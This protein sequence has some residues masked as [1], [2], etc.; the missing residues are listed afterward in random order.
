MVFLLLLGIVVLSFLDSLCLLFLLRFFFLSVIAWDG[1]DTWCL[2]GNAL[3]GKDTCALYGGLRSF[4]LYSADLRFANH[5]YFLILSIY[6]LKELALQLRQPKS[7]FHRK[8]LDQSHQAVPAG[9]KRGKVQCTISF[10]FIFYSYI[11]YLFLPSHHS[12]YRCFLLSWAKTL[13]DTFARYSCICTVRRSAVAL[14]GAWDCAHVIQ[15]FDSH[16]MR[17][18]GSP[19]HNPRH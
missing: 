3:F 1:Y 5:I 15:G 10:L 11:S 14:A 13:Y 8:D 19:P 18:S 4:F 12:L 9:R 16:H 2:G 7:C 17:G 6:I